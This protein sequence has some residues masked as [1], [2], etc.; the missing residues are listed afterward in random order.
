MGS[1]CRYGL[2]LALVPLACSSFGSTAEPKDGG[3]SP[4]PDGGDAGPVV[5][6][7]PEGTNYASRE[8][9]RIC[10]RHCGAG[11]CVDGECTPYPIAI[12]SAP[13]WYLAVDATHVYWTSHRSDVGAE[14]DGS[15]ARAPKQGGVNGN[16]EVIARPFES[17]DIEVDGEDILYTS[18]LDP[19]GVFRRKKD[20]SGGLVTLDTRE[21]VEI[22]PYANGWIASTRTKPVPESPTAAI[23]FFPRNGPFQRLIEMQ[24]VYTPEGLAWDGKDLYW[25]NHNGPAVTAIGSIGR[26]LENEVPNQEWTKDQNTAR[27]LAVDK[28]AVYWTSD[29]GNGAFRRLKDGSTQVTKIYE[30]NVKYG[31]LAVTDAYVFICAMGDGA[32]VRVPKE[33][34]PPLIVQKLSEPLGIT[35]DDTAIYLAERGTKTIWRMV[36]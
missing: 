18:I 13:P 32:L 1:V 6:V 24:N 3:V 7:C 35:Q 20:G 28:T 27:H 15:I 26:K 14:G 9:C 12:S 21:T 36:K 17:F 31:L 34:G 16:A 25:A 30:G 5:P 2:V 8:N 33:G 11:D 29:Q 22:A 10:K 19:M 23:T 4:S